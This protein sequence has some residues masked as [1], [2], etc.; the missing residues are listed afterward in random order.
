MGTSA[1]R[2]RGWEGGDLAAVALTAKVESPSRV[3]RCTGTRAGRAGAWG[4]LGADPVAWERSEA[5]QE[6]AR[7]LTSEAGSCSNN[8]AAPSYALTE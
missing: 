7:R 8:S 1:E 4:H 6:A 2:Q 3:E 5:Q